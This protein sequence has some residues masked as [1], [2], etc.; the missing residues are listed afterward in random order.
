MRVFPPQCMDLLGDCFPF[1]ELLRKHAIG[2]DLLN[3]YC[4]INW[5]REGRGREKRGGEEEERERLCG[6]LGKEGNGEV[7][8][9][10]NMRKGRKGHICN[11]VSM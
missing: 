3:K 11:V 2:V 8:R 1:Y 7:R 5:S 9:S 4:S 6:G 10:I